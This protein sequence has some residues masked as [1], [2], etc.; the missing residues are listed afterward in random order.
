MT[1]IFRL[2]GTIIEDVYEKWTKHICFEYYLW[3]NNLASGR[4]MRNWYK[5]YIR[6][7]IFL[8]IREG[9]SIL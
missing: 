1:Y 9:I 2:A 7:Y 3:F 8:T 6:G 5:D 4:S